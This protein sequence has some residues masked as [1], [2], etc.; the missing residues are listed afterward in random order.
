MIKCFFKKKKKSAF[1][2][3][4]IKELTLSYMKTGENEKELCHQL[5]Y[6][7]ETKLRKYVYS[8]SMEIC[9]YMQS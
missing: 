7:F 2:E 3:W 4:S 9:K 6:A 8:V 1:G 5:N